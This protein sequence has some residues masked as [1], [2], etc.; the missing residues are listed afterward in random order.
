METAGHRICSPEGHNVSPSMPPIPR[1]VSLAGPVITRRGRCRSAEATIGSRT[2]GRVLDCPAVQSSSS[3][4]TLVMAGPL[5]CKF[6]GRSSREA[7]PKTLSKTH[8]ISRPYKYHLLRGT[9]K[10]TS[11]SLQVMDPVVRL[12][13]PSSILSQIKEALS[14]GVIGVVVSTGYVCIVP[15]HCAV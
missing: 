8:P 13:L 3:L 6:Q 9:V 2:V 7:V 1:F 10:P 11:P 5:L 4:L 15:S 14:C 12:T